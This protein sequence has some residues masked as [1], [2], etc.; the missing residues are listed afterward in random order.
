M[1]VRLGCVVSGDGEV[2]AVP[3]LIRQIAQRLDPTLYVA[4]PEPVLV[5]Q[6]KLDPR[7]GELEKGIERAVARIQGQGGL[8]ILFIAANRQYIV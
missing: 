8:L 7:F 3:L 1:M 6:A 4:I 5:K 2:Q